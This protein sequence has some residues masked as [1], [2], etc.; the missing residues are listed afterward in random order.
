[1]VV[2]IYLNSIIGANSFTDIS[3]AANFET[4]LIVKRH[5]LTDTEKIYVKDN[6]INS[7]IHTSQNVSKV[8]KWGT[9]PSDRRKQNLILP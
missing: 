9:L 4:S 1:M 2:K 8:L 5:L 7:L 6:V 3:S